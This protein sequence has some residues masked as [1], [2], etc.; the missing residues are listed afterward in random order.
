MIDDFHRKYVKLFFEKIYDEIRE[1]S[2]GGAQS[3]LNLSKVKETLIPLP[4]LAEQH[5]IVSK[6]DALMPLCDQL[7]TRIQQANQQQQTIA[8][9]LVAQA[10]A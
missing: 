6:V 10:V 5:S 3:N 2:A 8:D 7:K 4:P 9:A 1:L